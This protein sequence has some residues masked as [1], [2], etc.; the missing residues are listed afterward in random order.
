MTSFGPFIRETIDFSSVEGKGIFLITGETGS[1]KTTIF[2]AICIALFG[3]SNGDERT[4]ESFK[5]DFEGADE[6]MK[7]DFTFELKGKIFRIIRVPKQLR[8]KYKGE[9]FTEELGSV[10]LF[11]LIHNE[12]V[13]VDFSKDANGKIQEL[14]GINAKQFRQI[15]MIPQGQFRKLITESSDE[16]E[17]IL[18]SIFD[19]HKYERFQKHLDSVNTSLKNS[20][21]DHKNVL[22]SEVSHIKCNESSDLFSAIQSDDKNILWIIEESKRMIE[23]DNLN[24]LTLSRELETN[25]K[26]KISAERQLTM[27]KQNN[28]L[29]DEFEKL[30][31]EKNELDER[32]EYFQSTK[33]IAEM[34]DRAYRIVPI[35]EHL[36]QRKQELILQM[37]FLENKSM[38]KLQFEAELQLKE[39]E[40]NSLNSEEAIYELTQYKQQVLFYHSIRPKVAAYKAL[41]TSV[42]SLMQ[43]YADEVSNMDE[44]RERT[45]NNQEDYK[46]I[47]KEIER[48]KGYSSQQEKANKDKVELN[49]KLELIRQLNKCYVSYGET[50]EKYAHSKESFSK[51]S[52]EKIEAHKYYDL[53]QKHWLE[54]QAGILAQGLKDGEECPVCG[55]QHHI[56][57]AILPK[58]I[59]SKE[60]LEKLKE[61][62]TKIDEQYNKMQKCYAADEQNN[63]NKRE[64]LE[65][66]IQA[67]NNTFDVELLMNSDEIDVFYQQKMV[68]ITE[69]SVENQLDLKHIH[70]QLLKLENA[71]E[72]LE[73]LLKRQ[74]SLQNQLKSLESNHLKTLE[75]KTIQGSQLKIIETELPQ[76]LHNET[77]LIN[78]IKV[79]EEK[80]LKIEKQR[81]SVKNA[82]DEIKSLLATIEGVINEGE[83]TLNDK[84]RLCDAAIVDF[85][86]ALKNNAFANWEH[87][88]EMKID[89]SR[90][91]LLRDELLEFEQKIRGNLQRLL[92]LS[93]DVKVIEKV[94]IQE[95][96][97]QCSLMNNNIEDV[98][99]Q[100]TRIELRIEEN[101]RQISKIEKK[102]AQY[103]ELLEEQA[104]INDLSSVA[105]G[106][107]KGAAR[108][109]FERYI[110]SAFLQEVVSAAN[111][112]LHKMSN[113]RYELVKS[114]GSDKRKNSGL[115]LEVF[116]YYTGKTRDI[117][118]LSGGEGFKAALSLALG[119]ADIAQA[120]AGGISLDTMFVDEGF[121]SLSADSLDNAINCLMDL[122]EGGR[123]VGIISHVQ[124][125]KDRIDTRLV[126]E[127]S[128]TGS[129]TYFEGVFGQ[130]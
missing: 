20:I 67:I 9:G 111:I 125:L 113:S 48:L 55:N 87:Y 45:I 89:E 16:R 52:E 38:E 30:K 93:E 69:E 13:A 75:E 82:R 8:K 59:P 91:K 119:L 31:I 57:L 51:I 81:D 100:L 68:D 90:I 98:A 128:K 25:R 88:E 124:E 28:I 80:I 83:K 77:N 34:A 49:Y 22:Y 78:Q 47:K 107:S 86:N 24:K 112:R 72:Q 97:K 110:L 65:D 40:Y 117:N 63:L 54:G 15:V 50:N 114:Q 74:E 10:S 19:V 37:K 6:I 2:D 79:I 122:K 64:L 58:S 7:I 71:Q 94:D 32:N 12:E 108:I 115:D 99:K 44:L 126:V 62:L 129:R 96:E 61:S 121:G 70:N 18:R 101:L 130:N 21:Y 56:K 60:D 85:D 76:E 41:K 106:S 103:L 29:L 11:E 17:K 1:G 4:V 84:K 36:K 92:Q 14:L 102:Y 123:L 127:K 118:T 42:D 39:A 116:D 43:K 33:V 66:A 5:S 23:E 3:E 46:S 120:Y 35:E 109:T 104:I 95:L 53:Q 27:A 105:N 73:S 26:K